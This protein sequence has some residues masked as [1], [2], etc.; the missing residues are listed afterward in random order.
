VAQGESPEFKP[1]Y[2]KNKFKKVNKKG[3]SR[4]IVTQ[5]AEP[6][7]LWDETELS[8]E[9]VTLWLGET[10]LLLELLGRKPVAGGEME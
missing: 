7:P 1:Q 9:T 3:Y 2:C 5:E 8:P 6:F 4:V 10:A